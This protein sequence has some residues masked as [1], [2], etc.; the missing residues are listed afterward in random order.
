MESIRIN[1]NKQ[2]G[3]E[4][5]VPVITYP[6]ESSYDFR[7]RSCKE[8]MGNLS[9][10]KAYHITMY[11]DGSNMQVSLIKGTEN[12]FIEYSVLTDLHQ[13]TVDGRRLLDALDSLEKAYASVANEAKPIENKTFQKSVAQVHQQLL[14]E[15]TP[16]YPLPLPVCKSE[17]DNALTFYMNYKTEG[18]ILTL[19]K[20]PDQAF[21]HQT[22][23][24]YLV[25]ENVHP[26][27]PQACK[28]IHSLVL[29]TFKIKSPEGYEY[30]QV[31]EGETVRINLKG[32]EGMLPMTTDVRGDV[33]KPTPYGYY[34]SATSTIRVDERTIKFYYE[35]KFFVKYNERRLRS[36]IVRYN[37]EQVM[38]DSNGCYL[39]KVY[40][41]KVND[42]G[43]IQ[44]TGENLKDARIQVTPGIVKQQE[45]VFNPE[46]MH[47]MTRITFDFGD[48]RPIEARIDIGTNDRLFHQLNEGK[49]KGY[50]V[51]KEGEDFR[52]FIPRKLTAASKNILRFMKFV[53]MVAFTLAAY[54][55]ATW[56]VT[57]HWPWPIERNVPATE[58]VKKTNR[59]NEEGEVTTVAD[60]EGN[61]GL[62]TDQTDKVTL[63][64]MDLSYLQNNTV[65]RRDSIRSNKY[66]DIV[67]TIFNGRLSEIK[68]KG[69]NG[70]IIPNPWWEMVWREVIVPNNIHSE[71]AKEVFEQV[72]TSD[73]NSLDVEKL[74]EE[75]SKRLMPT[76]DALRQGNGTMST[77]KVPSSPMAPNS[78][79]PATPPTQGGN[80][81]P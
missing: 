1:I 23:N 64:N 45:Y 44:F 61:S 80:V 40:E 33:S 69:Y 59:V 74:Y 66:K 50:P 67:N 47:D 73:H 41:D 77:P 27:R 52:M 8:D 54:A 42:A 28:H 68:M 57:Q 39:I 21:F 48:G 51:K 13:R 58:Q 3:R 79:K 14:S 81:V 46:P 30:G 10:D 53:A 2:L 63:E 32:K 75:L 49:V 5:L 34:D 4:G 11:P 19:I 16:G 72:I 29:R 18:E 7:L 55:L 15:A 17:E 31:K 6:A 78:Q 9:T 43:Y 26:T 76:G 71:A 70:K 24:I 22:T 65:W 20:Y 25:D 36:C 38:P 12:G 35:L 62:I 60:E 37:G 56:L